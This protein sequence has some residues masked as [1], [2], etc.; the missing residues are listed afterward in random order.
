MQNTQLGGWFVPDIRPEKI[1][2]FEEINTTTNES[3]ESQQ[4]TIEH[5]SVDLHP[6]LDG[7]LEEKGWLRTHAGAVWYNAK[8][9]ISVLQKIDNIVANIGTLSSLLTTD[10]SSLVAAVNELNSKML[11]SDMESISFAITQDGT[12]RSIMLFTGTDEVENQV[13][14]ESSYIR[15]MKRKNGQT[16][17]ETYFKSLSYEDV[18]VGDITI[19]TAGNTNI[20]SGTKSNLFATIST[21]TSNTGAFNV[22][23]YDTNVYAV[24]APGTKITNLIV[25]LWRYDG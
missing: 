5:K 9:K 25:R 17:S 20:H 21:W 13:V 11:L 1:E 24:G 6:V 3:G 22:V 7:K 18:A 15:V 4:E 10:K 12:N 16:V 2:T 14:F 19:P 8:Q 23:S